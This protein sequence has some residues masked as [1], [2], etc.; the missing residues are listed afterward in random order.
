M[1]DLTETEQKNVRA[2]LAFLRVRCGGRTPLAKV[3][4]VSTATLY[5]KTT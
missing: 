3:L 5:R 1:G 4:R 2:A